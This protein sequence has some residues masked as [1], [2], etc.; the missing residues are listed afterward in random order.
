MNDRPKSESEDW[1]E[2]H[3]EGWR[4]YFNEISEV[5][6]KALEWCLVLS[7]LGYAASFLKADTS[8]A[9]LV[10]VRRIATVYFLSW[11]FL[12]AQHYLLDMFGH[13]YRRRISSAWVAM[14]QLIAII[15]AGAGTYL[16]VTALSAVIEVL[17]THAAR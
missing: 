8:A 1:L 5:V 11:L 3:I 12:N 10:A 13:S 9:T 16:I 4:A 2:R 7:A 17:A 14:F 6:L 15:A